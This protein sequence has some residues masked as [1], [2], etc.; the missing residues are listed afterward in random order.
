MIEKDSLAKDA[1]L[2]AEKALGCWEKEF[3]Q[4]FRPHQAIEIAK[5]H[6]TDPLWLYPYY[7]Y[8][9]EEITSQTPILINPTITNCMAL[10]FELIQASDS[11]KCAVM[12]VYCAL[13]ASVL[14]AWK[15]VSVES[16]VVYVTGAKYWADRSTQ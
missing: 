9:K 12:S 13:K 1:L 10:A 2:Y 5:R 11:V 16:V 4:D 6:L 14:A 8:S 15:G 3:P 7:R